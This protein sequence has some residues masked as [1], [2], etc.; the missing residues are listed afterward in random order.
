MM[1][2]MIIVW[3]GHSVCGRGRW[4]TAFLVTSSL[5]GWVRTQSDPWF[6]VAC[7]DGGVQGA[8]TSDTRANQ[9]K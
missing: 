1:M 7:P 2:Q 4:G 5:A 3:R 8:D 9:I 6:A